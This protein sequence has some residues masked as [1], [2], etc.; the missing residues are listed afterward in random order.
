MEPRPPEVGFFFVIFVVN[1]FYIL[2]K[3]LSYKIKNN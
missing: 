3:I 1:G 2:I